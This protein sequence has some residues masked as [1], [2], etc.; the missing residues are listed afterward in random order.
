MAA[1]NVPVQVGIL[2]IPLT[3]TVNYTVYRNVFGTETFLL[4]FS[5]GVIHDCL[6]RY[7]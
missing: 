6:V 4:L 1:V 2:R 7:S 3:L 5:L